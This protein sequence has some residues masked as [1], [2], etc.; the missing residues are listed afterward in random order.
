ME[1]CD[2]CSQGNQSVGQGH[3]LERTGLIERQLN[4]R[5]GPGNL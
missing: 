3:R 4:A 1:A 5:P 2:Y